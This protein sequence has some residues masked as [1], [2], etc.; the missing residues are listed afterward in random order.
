MQEFGINS[1]EDKASFFAQVMDESGELRFWK[2]LSPNT[3]RYETHHMN[4]QKGDG[5]KFIGRGPLQTTFRANY[6]DAS[7][8]LNIDCVNNPELLEKPKHGCRA[9]AYYWKRNKISQVSGRKI[10]EFDKTT[11]I[12]NGPNMYGKEKRREYFRKFA[13]EYGFRVIE[14]S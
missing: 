14:D 9:S 4:S 7:K 6:L 5:E 10:S 12:V 3:N 2:E 11:R 1:P 8:A 13:A